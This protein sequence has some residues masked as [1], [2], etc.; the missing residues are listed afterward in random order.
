MDWRAVL[1]IA[2]VC[3]FFF[4]CTDHSGALI[5]ALG[6]V[7]TVAVIRLLNYSASGGYETS[8]R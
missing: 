2:H 1:Y 8:G 7:G 6:P 5:F 4:L 3:T